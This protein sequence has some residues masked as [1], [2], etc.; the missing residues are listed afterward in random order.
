MATMIVTAQPNPENPED[1]QAYLAQAVP[2]LVKAGGE[3][4]KRVRVS[5][6]VVGKQTFA[7]SLVMNFPD[8]AAIEGVFNSPEYAAI[9][10]HREKGF[11]FMNIV[12][13]EDM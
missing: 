2:M 10:P 8:A 4:V 13:A 12:I 5:K 1:T 6:A 9:A 7:A 3:I 11:A